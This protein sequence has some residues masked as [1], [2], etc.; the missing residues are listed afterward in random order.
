MIDST[1]KNL[2]LSSEVVLIVPAAP[3][4]YKV[5]ETHTGYVI[6]SFIR[7]RS[8]VVLLKSSTCK[9]N[10][11]VYYFMGAVSPKVKHVRA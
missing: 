8:L 5:Q 3:F 9:V 4:Y 7:A 1:Q 11:A 10:V 2:C 6:V